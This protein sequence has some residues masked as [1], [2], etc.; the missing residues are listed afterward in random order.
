[1]LRAVHAGFKYF[2][3]GLVAGLLFAPRRGEE[4]RQIVLDRVG[5]TVGSV[6]GVSSGEAEAQP[7]PQAPTQV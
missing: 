6:I 4:T 5:T 2:V 1:M 3:F 7:Q